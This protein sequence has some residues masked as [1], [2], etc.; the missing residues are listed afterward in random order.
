MNERTHPDCVHQNLL[1]SSSR[2]CHTRAHRQHL[3]EKKTHHS[4]PAY[5]A[6]APDFPQPIIGWRVGHLVSFLQRSLSWPQQ[7]LPLR[8][9]HPAYY[10]APSPQ[11]SS[12]SPLDSRFFFSQ[13]QVSIRK[14]CLI[15]FH[16]FDCLPADTSYPPHFL[17]AHLCRPVYL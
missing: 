1:Q 2:Q 11:F 3:L 16:G 12:T 7:Q 17:I 4:L 5:G 9:I 15:Y 8:S 6:T 13:Q 10:D 14:M